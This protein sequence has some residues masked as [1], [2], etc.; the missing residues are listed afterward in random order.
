MDV[1]SATAR[2]TWILDWERDAITKLSV[3][4]SDNLQPVWAPDGEGIAFVSNRG[5][6]RVRNIYWQRAD[7]S[8]EAVPLTTGDTIKV[9]YSWH[10]SGRFLAFTEATLAS[11]NNVMVMPIDGTT[12]AGLLPGQ[13]APF[14]NTPAEETRPQFSPDGKWLAYSSDESG[15]YEVYVRPFP[16]P[17]GRRQLSTAGGNHHQWSQARSELIYRS[18]VGTLMVVRYKVE[19]A[20]FQPDK[21]QLW[22]GKPIFVSTRGYALHPDGNRIA[23]E[24]E[25]EGLTAPLNRLTIV[26]GFFDEL[27]RLAPPQK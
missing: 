8:G 20:A 11:R 26:T 12:A 17:G 15:Q 18:L 24:P 21:P 6:N 16:G 10:P 9:G 5:A 19:E 27:R 13:P 1:T 14:V 3:G 2:N 25:I 7:G 4:G 23:I 22:S